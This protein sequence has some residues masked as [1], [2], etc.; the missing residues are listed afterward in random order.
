L[1][2]QKCTVLIIVKTRSPVFEWNPPD[3]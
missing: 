2:V 1:E 3:W